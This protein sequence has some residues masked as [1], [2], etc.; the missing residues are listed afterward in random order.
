VIKNKKITISIAL[1]LL[2]Q[3]GSILA[4]TLEEASVDVFNNH[5]E[6]KERLEHY[7][8][9]RHDYEISKSAFFP[10]VDLSTSKGREKYI[11]DPRTGAKTESLLD[12]KTLGATLNQNLFNGFYNYHDVQSQKNRA[13]SAE[14]FLKE[15]SDNILLELTDKYLAIMKK[16]AQLEIAKD[17]VN[18]HKRTYEKVKERKEAG[19]STVSELWQSE[20]RYALAQSELVASDL[21]YQDGMASFVK[22]YG[23]SVFANQLKQP[24]F[25]MKLPNNIEDAIS[26]ALV[27]NP[28]IAT[29]ERNTDVVKHQYKGSYAAYLPRLDFDL[30]ASKSENS[31]GVR[32][33]VESYSGALKLYYNIFNG[34]SDFER[35]RKYL[36]SM[37]YQSATVNNTKIKAIEKLQLSWNSYVLLSKQMEFLKQYS[38]L[39][40]KTLD[41][42]NEEFLLGRRT[43][44]D[45]L[46]AESEYN[47]AKK[48]LA[49]VEYDL[50]LAKYR[51]Y[52]G[53]YGL[54]DT[55]VARKDALDKDVKTVLY[56]K[57]S[58]E[59]LDSDIRLQRALEKNKKQEPTPISTPVV[60]PEASIAPAPQE[61]KAP[62][63]AQ[64][65]SPTPAVEPKSVESSNQTT[66]KEATTQEPTPIA[67][68]EVCYKVTTNKLVTRQAPNENAKKVGVLLKG[69]KACSDMN[70]NG[71]IKLPNGWS[72]TKYMEKI[73]TKSG[74]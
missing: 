63:I 27:N 60:V 7:R 70:E 39:S 68:K 3:A 66:P 8:D 2:L 58:P 41:A 65:E 32:G 61:V 33:F 55:L 14:Y 1:A 11:T 59:A 19:Y 20:S 17:N 12:T 52:D 38:E 46:G 35:T 45:L 53:I 62:I 4:L 23:K 29:E 73:E 30:T 9:V 31:S 25:E 10:K 36:T 26:L 57:L 47:G 44:I 22:I 21:A 56:N 64:A 67:I 15:K 71:W 48:G 18:A 34:F 16:Y 54:T 24:Q 5:P 51:V 13:L 69:W 43:I 6:I 50:L 74:L 28:S 42:Y 49:G 72:S 40:K 37:S